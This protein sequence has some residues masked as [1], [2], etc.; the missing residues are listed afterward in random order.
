MNYV[1]FDPRRNEYFKGYEA[2]PPEDES[3]YV[4][5]RLSF[6]DVLIDAM[7]FDSE[8]DALYYLY[9]E[10]GM[11]YTQSTFCVICVPDKLY[12][13]LLNHH[14]EMRERYA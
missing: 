9:K 13:K 5:T 10:Y 1:L 2:Y 4:S 8:R 6:C 7:R 12:A 3:D 14:I 11:D